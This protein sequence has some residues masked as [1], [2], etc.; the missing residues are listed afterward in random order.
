MK[1]LD[2][3]KVAIFTQG[4]DTSSTDTKVSSAGVH[5]MHAVCA[6]KCGEEKGC[7]AARRGTHTSPSPQPGSLPVL[8]HCVPAS[9]PA[10]G[11]AR[12]YTAR[13]CLNF[14]LRTTQLQNS[15]V[16]QGT[17]LIKTAEEL[18]NYSKTEEN[19]LEEYIKGIHDLGVKVWSMSSRD[20]AN[21][22][23]RAATVGGAAA[24]AST[25]TGDGV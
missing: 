10:S 11:P 15:C 25:G 8:P 16:L 19:K 9:P 20:C 3:A 24:G 12:I 7:S 1:N 5:A 17:V 22:C 14:T 13:L 18:E 4:I 21:G 6:W 2:D 23:I